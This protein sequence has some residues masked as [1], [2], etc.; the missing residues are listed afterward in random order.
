MAKVLDSPQK[1]LLIDQDTDLLAAAAAQLEPLDLSV[2][3]RALQLLPQTFAGLLPAQT[4]LVTASAL[5]DLVSVQWL[6][7]LVKEVADNRAALLVVL[8]YAGRFELSPQHPDDDLLRVL[9]N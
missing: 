9:V 2:E 7:A 6:Q 3:T 1:W 5:I 8:S 4:R